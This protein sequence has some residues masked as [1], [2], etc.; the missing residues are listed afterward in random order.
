MN[1]WYEISSEDW[2]RLGEQDREI[3]L[4]PNNDGS[5]KKHITLAGRGAACARLCIERI[6]SINCVTS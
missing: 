6:R 4:T 2:D 1:D 5:G 3:F